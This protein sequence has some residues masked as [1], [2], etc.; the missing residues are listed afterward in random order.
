[1][2]IRKKFIT[3]SILFGILPVVIS[4]AIT[5]VYFRAKD[6]DIIK[7]NVTTVAND[8]SIIL[9]TFFEQ[10]S[11]DLNFV[12]NIQITQELLEDSNN[13][14]GSININEYTSIVSQIL[15]IRK[16]QQSYIYK[17][18]L[19]NKRGEV[20]AATD[21]NTINSTVIF[22]K[23]D[24]D[25]LINRQA[26]VTDIDIN[27]RVKTAIIAAPVFV[28]EQYQGAMLYIIDMSYFQNMVRNTHFFKTGKVAIFDGK[29]VIAASSS[30]N[31]IS[32]I[33]SINAP[34]NL[35]EQW[36]KID[37]NKYPKGIIEYKLNG[38]DKIG[39][40]SKISDTGWVVLSGVEWNEFKMPLNKTIN[41]IIIII[42]FIFLLIIISYTFVVNYFSKPI[43][44]L[45][46]VIRKVREGN[47]KGRF[48]YKEDNEFGEISRAFNDLIER[49][50]KKRKQI[51]DKNRDLESLTSNIPGG[52]HR[53]RIE[54]GEYLI[55]YLSY[56]CL[57]I[58]GYKPEEFH[59]FYGKSI[60]DLVYEKDRQRVQQEIIDQIRMFDKYTVEFR[61]KRKDGSIIWLIDNGRIV[62]DRDGKMYSYS[63]V[64]NITDAKIAEEKLRVSEERYRIIMSQTEDIIFEWDVKRDSIQYSKNLKDRFNVELNITEI[65]KKLVNNDF[66]YKDDIRKFSNL[67]NNIVCGERYG[68]TE[69]RIKK[70]SDSYTWC[71]MRITSIFDE[72]GDIVRA[73]GAIIDIDKQKKETENLLFMAE[74]DSATGLYNKGTSQRLVEKYMRN[75]E[76]SSKGALFVIDVDN[77]KLVNDTLGHLAG[78]Y[79]LNRISAMLSQ[80]FKENSII[81]RIGG[82]EFIVFLKDVSSKEFIQNKADE[83]VEGFRKINIEE[84]WG[85]KVSGSIGIAFYPLHGNSYEKLFI[86]ADK[87]VYYSKKNGKDGYCIFEDI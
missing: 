31:I 10:N 68:E 52:V 32:N 37:S 29:G 23:K 15:C 71:K 1:M 51:E 7:Q 3:F 12:S 40:Y 18:S 85:I 2:N 57:N 61:I 87:A 49:I 47:Y 86:S 33:N 34:N 77:F 53:N 11:R 4:T 39:Y 70:D 80:T 60:F 19:V 65:S 48:V 45:L 50:E 5:V 6:I 13:N 36:R 82:D 54:N 30:K 44:D 59:Q 24:M 20:I 28:K 78:D 17:A 58:L 43:Y 63:V 14:M 79:V 66:I 26:V 67:I 56:G 35:Y 38:V 72:N 83:L 76:Q 69:V 16:K 42:L 8:Q 55:D 75:A 73:I 81:G 84:G 41:T 62:K 64:L 22:S 27:N 21:N 74:R 46:E 25:K 9:S